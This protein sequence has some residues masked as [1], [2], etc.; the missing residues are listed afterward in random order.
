M[1]RADWSPPDWLLWQRAVAGE[2]VF[3]TQRLTLAPHTRADFPA[4]VALW[5]DPVVVRFIGGQPAT[6]EEVWAR[7][8]RYSG[9]WAL[10]GHGFW[11]VRERWGGDYVGDVGFLEARRT[12]VAGFD[13]APEIGWSLNARHHGKGYASEAVQAALGW[14]AARFDRCVAMIDPENAPSLAVAR[15]C[16]FRHFADSRYNAAAVQLWE[17]DFG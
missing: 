16:G 6:E 14:G 17:H 9:T 8:L 12:G 7:L 10:F 11:A 13:G 5:G 1:A 2:Q 3:E 4:M 15:R